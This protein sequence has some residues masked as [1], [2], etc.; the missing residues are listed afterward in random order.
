MSKREQKEE[1]EWKQSEQVTYWS[2]EVE[3]AMAWINRTKEREDDA[4]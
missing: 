4:A 2:I 1:K 3:S